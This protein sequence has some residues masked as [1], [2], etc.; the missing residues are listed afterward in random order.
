LFIQFV[1]VGSAIATGFV[2]LYKPHKPSIP[3]ALSPNN[4]DKVWK[5]V[6][7]SKNFPSSDQENFNESSS[8]LNR[9][10]RHISLSIGVT[11]LSVVGS[12]GHPAFLFL[13]L[14]GFLYLNVHFLRRS[15]YEMKEKKRV[16]I[17]FI[18][19]IVVT[20]TF[21]LRSYFASGLFIFLYFLSEK[22]LHN[23][24]H[25]TENVLAELMADLPEVVW[26]SKSASSE[27]HEKIEVQVALADLKVDDIIVVHAGETVPVDGIV[28]IGEAQV[29]CHPLLG[30][31]ER[32]MVSVEDRVLASTVV[33]SGIL[34]IQV[35]EIDENTHLTQAYRSFKLNLSQ[36]A[37]Q[38]QTWIDKGTLPILLLSA[39]TVPFKGIQSGVSVLL[40]YF[41]YDLRVV[42]PIGTLNFMKIALQE[43]IIIRDSR[44]LESLHSIDTVLFFNDD[45]EDGVLVYELS[46]QSKNISF[47]S[48]NSSKIQPKWQSSS[49]IETRF[50]YDQLEQLTDQ[51]QVKILSPHECKN[52]IEYLHQAGKSICVINADKSI[53]AMMQG[54]D[55]SVAIGN[56]EKQKTCLAQICIPHGYIEQL[57][58]LF[59]LGNAYHANSQANLWSTAI[60]SLLCLGGIYFL[61]FGVLT[62][63]IVDYLGLITGVTSATLPSMKYSLQKKFEIDRKES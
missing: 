23:V 6:G 53:L 2:Q 33:Q 15:Y 14:P 29:V 40:T 62:A 36:V 48:V 59:D 16:G 63:I 9:I 21:L 10:N 57:M 51:A 37:D 56:V 5:D 50:E 13:S 47:R 61:H 49:T 54:G 22:L 3:A 11:G 28:I 32:C 12:F 4:E 38:S 27:Q 45:L 34:W 60:P 1:L 20:G 30:L 46:K 31:R 44:A 17:A 43:G 52:I 55:V 39:G 18:D 7:E 35:K 58:H 25:S 41:G 19:A 8:G 42:A 26:L 24:E